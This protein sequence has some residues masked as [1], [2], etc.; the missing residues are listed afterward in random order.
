MALQQNTRLEFGYGTIRC[1]FAGKKGFGALFFNEGKPTT[2]G[3]IRCDISENS[4]NRLDLNVYPFSMIF[5]N[6]ESVDA[7]IDLLKHV[8]EVV[9]G[10]S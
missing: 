8:R 9:D 6:T 2:I 10:K 5:N 7:F 1:R 3:K 4:A